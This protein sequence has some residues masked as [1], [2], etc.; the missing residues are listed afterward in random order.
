MKF[1]G[2][3]TNH[4]TQI[5]TSQFIREGE[6]IEERL[7]K[8]TISGEPIDTN[9]TPEIY[10][11]RK[12]GVDPLCDIRTDKMELAQQAFDTYTKTHMLARANR[13]DMG[14][15]NAEEF[16]YVTDENGNIVENIVDKK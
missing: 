11:E 4:K 3:V 6:S 5:D 12:D 8:V 13:G 15:K 10:Q 2:K 1:Q 7:R 14:S 16:T 9:V